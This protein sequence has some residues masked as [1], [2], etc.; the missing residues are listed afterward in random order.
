[1]GYSC[2]AKAGYA[3]DA[4]IIQLQVGFDKQTS[5]GWKNGLLEYFYEIGREQ[6]DGAIT[7]S[8]YRHGGEGS[9]C[10]RA[11]TFRI[12]PDG[13]IHHWP[14]ATKAM[15]Q[16]AQNVGLIEY[17]KYHNSINPFIT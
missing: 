15:K 14:T 16:T 13:K 4:L 17:N 10:V 7:G 6:P 3:K 1:M 9:S 11:G 12:E 8:I 2:T 5:N